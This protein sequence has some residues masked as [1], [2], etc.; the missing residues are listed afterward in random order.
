MQRRL[1]SAVLLRALPQK[2]ADICM[3]CYKLLLS[4]C[5]IL[6][7][8]ISCR[9]NAAVPVPV[10][11]PPLELSSF[12]KTS[13][14]KGVAGAICGVQDTVFLMA[15]GANFP[16]KAP[17]NGGSKRYYDAGMVI[18]NSEHR[19]KDVIKTF[20]LPQPLAYAAVCST[21][22]GV[23]YA[24]GENENG[25]TDKVMLLQWDDAAAGIKNISLPSLPVPVT[26]GSMTAVA[27]YLFFAGGE[28]ADST[29][30]FMWV[31]NRKELQK[32]WKAL[33]SLPH[34]LSHFVMT[35]R[36]QDD[37]ILI[38]VFGGRKKNQ[39]T[40]SDWY[41]TIYQFD[42]ATQ[43]W[44]QKGKLP[45]ALAAGTGVQADNQHIYLLG[46]DRGDTFRETEKLLLK[47]TD[48]LP[49]NER[50][51]LLHKKAVV[52]AAHPGFS[53]EIICYNIQSS[54]CTVLGELP[55]LTPVT[56]TAV[57]SA[58]QLILP[59]GEIRAGVR[60]SSIQSAIMQVSQ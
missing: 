50:D 40:V 20:Q 3:K 30:A 5:M 17:W 38:N 16:D 39:K 10:W 28:T 54:V 9:N 42:L 55:F 53:R 1:A 57:F 15:G 45:Y 37:H 14:A 35:G 60:S 58:G 49:G 11:R 4:V 24:G 27:D 2:S 23:I 34:G 36:Q 41:D 56:T 32:G 8:V 25:I 46:G 44:Q 7:S 21:P 18:A 22:D 48:T 47:L 52:Q 43:Q 13:Y 33:P 6:P 12:M 59:S 51:S 19:L 26:N 29:S 31:L